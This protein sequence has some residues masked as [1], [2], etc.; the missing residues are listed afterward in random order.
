MFKGQVPLLPAV[1]RGPILNRFAGS[2]C[3]AC[4]PGSSKPLALTVE[5]HSGVSRQLG[6]AGFVNSFVVQPILRECP[7]CLAVTVPALRR[8]DSPDPGGHV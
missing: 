3:P 1:A 4:P 6:G 5:S 7:L 2:L 8:P